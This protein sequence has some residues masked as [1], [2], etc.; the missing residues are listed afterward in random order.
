M[1]EKWLKPFYPY[2][3]GENKLG[4][5]MILLS[6]LLDTVN[7]AQSAEQRTSFNYYLPCGDAFQNLL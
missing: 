4:S 6:A 2:T 5:R 1:S 3:T 7:K